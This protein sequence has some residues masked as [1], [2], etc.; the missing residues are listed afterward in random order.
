MS[1]SGKALYNVNTTTASV[2]DSLFKATELQ[3]LAPSGIYN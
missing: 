1:Q 2:Q 3:D